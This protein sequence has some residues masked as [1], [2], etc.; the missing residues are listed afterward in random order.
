VWSGWQEVRSAGRVDESPTL[1]ARPGDRLDA[2]VVRDGVVL[3]IPFAQGAWRDA[4]PV[5]IATSSRP[6]AVFSTTAGLQVFA[7]SGSGGLVS[8]VLSEGRWRG[9][10]LS[11]AP[12][13][14]LSPP[15]AVVDDSGRID[16][17]ARTGSM[18]V[19]YS[20]GHIQ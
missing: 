19:Q 9:R 20:I 13:D 12:G 1:A 7:R 16:L 15:G 8:A 10:L 17:Y 18:R 4:E 11:T 6:E 3:H 5:G 14:T 2:F